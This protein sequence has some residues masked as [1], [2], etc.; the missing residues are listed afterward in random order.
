MNILGTNDAAVLT[1]RHGGPDRDQ[2]RLLSTS[3]T[4]TLSDVD[5]P[6]TFVAQTRRGGHNATAPSRSTRPAPGPTRPTR[7]TTSSWRGTTYTDSFTVA[8]ADGTTPV[9]TVNILGTN[10]AAVITGTA[11]RR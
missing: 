8:S 9:V 6:A 1:G 5:S 10:D 2:L 4:L 11:R 3:G 7:R